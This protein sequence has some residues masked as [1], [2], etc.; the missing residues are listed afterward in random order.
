MATH[1]NLLPWRDE[2]RAEQTRQFVSLTII[3]VIFTLAIILL[4]HANLERLISFQ[5]QRN[6]ILTDEIKKLDKELEQ[7]K[8]LEDT[9]EKLLS[10][11]E[12]I[13]SLQQKRPQIVHLFDELVRSVPE[14]LHLDSIKQSGES[15]TIIGMAES[16]GRVSAYMRNIDAS[17]WMTKPRLTVIE[18]KRKDGR[19]SEFT[20]TASQS[21]PKDVEE[22]K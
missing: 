7:I 11:M 17:D 18:S 5:E 19:G 15:L 2:L 13:Q 10:R 21:S 16:N 8:D 6:Q 20:L 14:G 3:S 22:E 12:I 9:K 4:I 1:I